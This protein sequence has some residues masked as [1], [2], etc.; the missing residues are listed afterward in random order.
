MRKNNI[1]L[2]ISLSMLV[3]S[4]ATYIDTIFGTSLTFHK[5]EI[6]DEIT[7]KINLKEQY[8]NSYDLQSDDKKDLSEFPYWNILEIDA[9]RTQYDM[10]RTFFTVKYILQNNDNEKTTFLEERYHTSNSYSSTILSSGFN[11]IYLLKNQ[12]D[13]VE[14]REYYWRIN[15]EDKTFF[16]I[17]GKNPIVMSDS[18]YG[19]VLDMDCSI[20]SNAD[21]SY[22]SKNYSLQ[23]TI[24]DE[25]YYF[26][27]TEKINMAIEGPWSKYKNGIQINF[28]L[29]G[30]TVD[31]YLYQSGIFKI[32]IDSTFSGKMNGERIDNEMTKLLFGKISISGE[33]VYLFPIFYSIDSRKIKIKTN[34]W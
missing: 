28:Q 12:F 25:N 13:I 27:P 23:I 32:G 30:Q 8:Y 1:I 6:L 24:D 31:K 2:I 9:V 10:D 21:L 17:I 19:K 22:N 34:G 26:F 5:K 16:I 3:S 20:F 14:K 18:I 7:S 4:C 15:G 33:T 11:E 29:Q